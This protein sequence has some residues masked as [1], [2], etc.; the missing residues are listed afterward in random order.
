[1]KPT[2]V[3]HLDDNGE[4]QPLEGITNVVIYEETEAVRAAADR[5]REVTQAMHAFMQ[6]Y[7]DALRPAVEQMA[8]AF[9]TMKD[10]NLI[11][12][13]GKPVKRSDRPAWQ[14]PYGPPRRR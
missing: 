13:Q 11:D 9:Q 1:M 14:S 10:A 3:E 4:W 5:L 8:R 2:R 7:A 12:E 6:A